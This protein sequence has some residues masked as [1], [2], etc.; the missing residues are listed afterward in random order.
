MLYY[1]TKTFENENSS[2]Y[3]MV[4]DQIYINANVKC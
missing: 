4:E 2:T 1:Y 3:C